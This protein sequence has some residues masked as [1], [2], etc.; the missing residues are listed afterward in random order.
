MPLVRA[1]AVSSDVS[2]P[3][4]PCGMCRQFIR[5]FCLDEVS[6]L[7]VVCSGGGGGGSSSSSCCWDLCFYIFL[8]P[9]ADDGRYTIADWRVLMMLQTPIFMFDGEDN[10][11]KYEVKTIAELLP[12]SFGPRDM[13]R[14]KG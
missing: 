3:A 5:E 12:M 8:R 9:S 4:S 14:N 2:P 13:D 6:F 11:E 10:W 7:F 1:V